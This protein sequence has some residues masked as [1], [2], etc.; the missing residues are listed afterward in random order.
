MTQQPNQ[1]QSPKTDGQ[2]ALAGCPS[3][4]TLSVYFDHELPPAEIEAIAAHVDDC[5]DCSVALRDLQLMRRVLAAT[6]PAPS[7][8]VIR[9]NEADIEG[10][11]PVVYA[12]GP[13]PPVTPIRRPSLLTIPF[14]PA[15]AAVAALLLIAVVTGDLLTRDDSGGGGAF[16]DING[17]LVPVADEDLQPTFEAAGQTGDSDTVEDSAEAPQARDDDDDGFWTWWRA[18]EVLLI[19]ILAGLLATIYLQRR[20]RQ[21]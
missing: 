18:A 4:E 16:I 15:L 10:D 17:T 13:I 5:A 20:S 11:R 8:R 21:V 9:L 12:D 14:A 2:H 19:A 3:F 1:E 7:R 6:S